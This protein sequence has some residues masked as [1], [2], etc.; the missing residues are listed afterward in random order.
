M[1][2]ISRAWSSCSSM[3]H[4]SSI[5][6]LHDRA[7]IAPL[8]MRPPQWLLPAKFDDAAVNVKIAAKSE[9]T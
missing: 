6:K 7:F 3:L 8:A 1:K 2:C 5:Q 4:A 9:C